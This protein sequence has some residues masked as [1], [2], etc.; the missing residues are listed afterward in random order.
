MLASSAMTRRGNEVF[1][2]GCFFLQIYRM[3]ATKRL[4]TLFQVKFCYHQG[5]LPSF[6]SGK[7]SYFVVSMQKI[8]RWL[9]RDVVR[10]SFQMVLSLSS[11]RFGCIWEAYYRPQSIIKWSSVRYSIHLH[12]IGLSCV[13]ITVH[14]AFQGFT[15]VPKTMLVKVH[16]I[17]HVLM[18]I[19]HVSHEMKE[20]STIRIDV[21]FVIFS[22]FFISYNCFVFYRW[23]TCTT[24]QSL[25]EVNPTAPCF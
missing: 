15:Y 17:L 8:L 2:T 6:F 9:K 16:Y 22:S 10:S 23:N 18:F 21:F 1:F 7:M 24:S 11:I 20:L 25:Q 12:G 19:L 14:F 4:L 3:N 13:Y 5:V